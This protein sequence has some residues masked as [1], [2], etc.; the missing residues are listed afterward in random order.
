MTKADFHGVF[1]YLVTPVMDCGDIDAGNT[2][3]S[4]PLR[5]R[6]ADLPLPPDPS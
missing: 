3:A 6:G 4:A 1:P 5:P 2:A